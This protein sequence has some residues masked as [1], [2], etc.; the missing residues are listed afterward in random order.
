MNRTY[1]HIGEPFPPAIERGV[2][3]ATDHYKGCESQLSSTLASIMEPLLADPH[4]LPTWHLSQLTGDGYPIEFAFTSAKDSVRY[5]AEIAPPRNE[6]GKRL[7]QTRLLLHRLGISSFDE[8][9]FS[10]F[11]HWQTFGPL[12]FGAWMGVRHTCDSTEH[13]IYIDIP[14]QAC[15]AVESYLNCCLDTPLPV[16]KRRT[17]LQMAGFSPATGGLE[18]YFSVYN[19]RPWEVIS[20]LHPV[21]LEAHYDEVLDHFQWAYG[22]PITQRLP[23]PIFGFSYSIQPDASDSCPAFSL[24][25]FADTLFL[26]GADARRKLLRYYSSLGIDMSY[27]AEMSEPESR[28]TGNHNHHGLF[29]ISIAGNRPAV[30]HIGLRPPHPCQVSRRR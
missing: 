21:G 24:Y 2:S 13:K 22:K 12:K 8:E 20:L 25:T 26:N 18:F 4:D 1:R 28:Q 15:D 30:S 7:A 5:T 23:G 16:T 9:R 17:A 29:G 11:E 10:M 27:Y 3:I 19:M 14:P 6:V